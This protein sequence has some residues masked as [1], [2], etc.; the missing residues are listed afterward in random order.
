MDVLRRSNFPF[1]ML[2]ENI[3][4][5]CKGHPGNQSASDPA[6]VFMLQANL[7]TGGIILTFVSQHQTM[8][9]VGQ[10]QI[11]YLLSKACHNEPFTEE[12][13]L[14]GNLPRQNLIPL[15]DDSS[16][17]DG[18]VTRQTVKSIPSQPIRDAA[19]VQPPHPPPSPERTWAYFTFPATFLVALKSLAK[20]AIVGPDHISTDDA[21]SA[22]IWQSVIRARIPRLDPM[23][24]S[25]FG[26]SI[27]VRSR[28]NIPVTYPGLMSNMTYH[29]Y[30]LQELVKEPLGVVASRLR[31]AL[32][33]TTST[34]VYDTRA[35]ATFLN[36]NPDKNLASNIA[37]LN[38]STDIIFSSWAKIDIYDLDFNLGLG[39]PEAVRRPRFSTVE[40]LMFLMPRTLN[41][42]ITAAMCL[43]NDDMKR[44][45][46]DNEFRKYGTYVG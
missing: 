16:K 18:E 37:T 6:P 43:R 4:A 45:Q 44:L 17:L 39:K 14:S 41:G 12:E 5:P 46:E 28:L 1:S 27:D 24:K 36:S 8:D 9:M 35:L 38:L 10:G 25:T 20:E 11:M 2:D 7:I 42:E 3:V 26:R 30:T 33:S 29:T 40:S 21:L 19:D 34:L 23:I 15:L 13:L 32:N 22:F 31:S